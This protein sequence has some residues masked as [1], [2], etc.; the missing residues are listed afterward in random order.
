MP[1]GRSKK[2]L[3]PRWQLR[4]ADEQAERTFDLS[5]IGTCRD[6]LNERVLVRAVDA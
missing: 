4:T 6:L 5:A 3:N 1:P 2:V